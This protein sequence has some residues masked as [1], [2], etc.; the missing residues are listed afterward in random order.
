MFERGHTPRFGFKGTPRGTP[1]EVVDEMKRVGHVVVDQ[2]DAL[3]PGV[4][5]SLSF[6][7]NR[8]WWR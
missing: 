7:G 4:D 6:T 8:R 3:L 2:V 1:P 5:R